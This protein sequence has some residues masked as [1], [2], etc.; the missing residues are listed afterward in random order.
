MAKTDSFLE[1]CTAAVS[2]CQD[3]DCRMVLVFVMCER[4][5]KAKVLTMTHKFS[6]IQTQITHQDLYT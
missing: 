5:D 6:E 4:D 3:Y 1:R 2:N